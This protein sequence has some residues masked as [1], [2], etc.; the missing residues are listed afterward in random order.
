M[1]D[2]KNNILN[3]VSV[4]SPLITTLIVVL[5]GTYLTQQY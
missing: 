2:D 4:F 3:I 5:G 1:A